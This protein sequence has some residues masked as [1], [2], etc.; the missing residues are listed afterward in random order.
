MRMKIFAAVT[1]L[2]LVV[3][4]LVP[5][6]AQNK[7]D[8]SKT[9]STAV[10]AQVAMTLE[11]LAK[12]NGQNGAKAYVAVDGI[13]YDVT[14]VKSWK[15]G[16]HKGYKAGNDLTVA[17]MKKSPHGTAVL[18]KLEKVGTLAPATQPETK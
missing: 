2:L 10:K 6:S 3:S 7:P 4:I 14:N 8:S 15:G 11:E 13:I 1:A 16:K 12:F 18:K 17:I 5:L 9:D